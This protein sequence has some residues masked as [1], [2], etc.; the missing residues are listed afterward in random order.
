MASDGEPAVPPFRLSRRRTRLR[1]YSAAAAVAVV[2]LLLAGLMFDPLLRSMLYP[3][4]PV[5][6]PEPPPGLAEVAV[7]SADGTT[8]VAWAGPADG[9]PSPRP[10]PGRP[11][12][13]L[14]HGNGENLATME[15]S[16]L[17]ARL[18]RLDVAYLAVDY[19]GYG[20]S[21]GEPSEASLVAG[22]EAAL[23]RLREMHPDRPVVVLGW[24]LGAAVA[25]QLAARTGEPLAGLIL[26]SPWSRLADTAAA[27][28]PAFLV[29]PAVGGRYDSVA[30]ASRT[31]APALLVHGARDRI[32]PVEQGRELAEAMAARPGADS[33]WVEV[34]GAGH[35][36]LLGQEEPW[37][38]MAVFLDHAAR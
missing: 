21:G 34:P 32:I 22:A 28:F 36:D 38:E 8:L 26:L 3:A 13:L 15:R 4:P 37:R 6:V 33:R 20:R 5:P 35:N 17:F 9:G 2:A 7:E 23:V 27:H 14:F 19:P 12:V 11:A 29:R 16:G 18:D 10:A 24:S 31:A 25:M 30:A 1:H